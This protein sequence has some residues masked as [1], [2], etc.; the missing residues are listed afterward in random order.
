MSTNDIFPMDDERSKV[1]HHTALGQVTA[2]YSIAERIRAA[3]EEVKKDLAAPPAVLVVDKQSDKT[4]IINIIDNRLVIYHQNPNVLVNDGLEKLYDEPTDKYRSVLF[5]YCTNC[6]IFVLSKVLKLAVIQCN[7]CQISIRGG[8]IGPVE[9]FRCH[10]TSVDIRSAFPIL[11]CELCQNVH[12][13]QRQDEASYAIIGAIDCTINKVH[14]DTGQRLSSYPVEDLFNSRRFYCL[15]DREMFYVSEEYLL[16]NIEAHLMALP[17]EDD[18]GQ[19]LPFG[20]TPPSV[21]FFTF[22]LNNRHHT[23]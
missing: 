22:Q 9:L 5:L 17:A 20:Q 13:Y 10:D 1:V 19:E 15:C 8:A 18:S 7:Q 11:T 4:L 12:M 2:N 14:S 23:I 3:A 16:N 6:R 21:G